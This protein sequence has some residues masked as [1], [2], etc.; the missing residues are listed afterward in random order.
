MERAA[1]LEAL[2][3]Q[4]LVPQPNDFK[5]ARAPW[6]PLVAPFEITLEDLIAFF[7]KQNKPRV[8]VPHEG[9]TYISIEMFLEAY[10][11]KIG[12]ENWWDV[13][14][15]EGAAIVHLFMEKNPCSYYS[16]E[17]HNFYYSSAILQAQKEGNKFVIAEN[18]S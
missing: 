16:E 11:D 5:A 12:M 10:A 1:Q 13:D 15:M 18:L 6:I 3:A 4:R 7:T 17:K 2:A 9:V 8:M 14:Y